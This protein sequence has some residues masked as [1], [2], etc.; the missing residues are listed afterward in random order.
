MVASSATTLS[1]TSALRADCGP[2][3]TPPPSDDSPLPRPTVP[4]GAAGDLP[5]L[6]PA[7]APH[8][9]TELLSDL[10]S[11]HHS[12]ASVAE[13]HN[14]SLDA[15][16]I[17]LQHPEA[18]ELMA[19][20]ESAAYAHVR[21]VGALNLSHA[22]HT[23]VKTLETFNATP[24]PADPLDPSYLRA[25]I[26]ARKAAWLLYRF[27]RLTPLSDADIAA[28]RSTLRETRSV[29]HHVEGAEAEPPR[30]SRSHEH[31]DAGRAMPTPAQPIER[32][33]AASN[34]SRREDAHPAN[35]S[36]TP[37]PAQSHAQAP[38]P[39]PAPPANVEEL[40]SQLTVIADSLG[41]DI[42]DLED[43]SFDPAHVTIGPH[44]ST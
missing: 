31:T 16:L 27:S 12:L 15:L 1:G 11:P 18:R 13:K 14:L 42:S 37:Q 36:P 8:A 25:S 44:N 24:R 21:Y 10:A 20:H 17:W 28:A 3:S 41:I 7:A 39:I 34:A 30:V 6:P 23:T 19:L 38:R 33:T 35:P 5:P 43:P 32:P 40:L 26:H 9:A 2:G 4:W 29:R 22:V